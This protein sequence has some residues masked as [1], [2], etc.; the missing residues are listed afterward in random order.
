MTMVLDLELHQENSYYYISSDSAY[1]QIHNHVYN[2]VGIYFEKTG[3]KHKR[4][5]SYFTQQQST[6]NNDLYLNVLFINYREI[7]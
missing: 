7:Y 3:Y 2:L 5:K 4:H 1:I 6:D